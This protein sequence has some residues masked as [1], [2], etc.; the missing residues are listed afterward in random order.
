MKTTTRYLFFG[1]TLMLL[2]F[3][4][5]AGAEVINGTP[6]DDDIVGDRNGVPEADTISGFDGNDRLDGR[7]GDDHLFG[8]P[9]DD[10]LEGDDG[11]DRLEAGPSGFLGDTLSGGPGDDSLIGGDGNDSLVGGDSNDSLVGGDGDDSLSGG[12]GRDQLT[13]GTGS[14][15]F[16]FRQQLDEYDSGVGSGNRDR[17]T[18]F[19]SA[20]GDKIDV[21]NIDAD[22]TTFER[23]DFIFVG[24]IDPQDELATG[25]IGYIETGGVTIL[26]ANNDAD[27][28]QDFEIQISGVNLGLTADDFIF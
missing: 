3:S 25:E 7:G 4:A 20:E 9:G 5:P 12:L 24:R 10:D 27:A 22:N 28:A 11:N 21:H 6:G 15:T 2:A 19:R 13:G 17:I 18:D 16:P 26:R 8:G 1:L 23:E 14:D